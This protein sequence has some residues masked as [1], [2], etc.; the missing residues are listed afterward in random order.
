MI[1]S[2]HCFQKFFSGDLTQ[3][4]VTEVSRVLTSPE[5]TR[6]KRFAQQIANAFVK[7]FPGIKSLLL[8]RTDLAVFIF[9]NIKT[10]RST[11]H[12]FLKGQT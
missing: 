8:F 2:V 5:N 9:L 1:L 7:R 12:F 4:M 3:R 6:L 10:F 11:L